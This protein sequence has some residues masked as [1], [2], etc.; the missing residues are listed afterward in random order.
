MNNLRGTLHRV[1]TYAAQLGLIAALVVLA[2]FLASGLPRIANDRTDA[3]L[4]SDI[5]RL[6]SSQRD[7]TFSLS[8]FDPEFGP[9]ADWKA[10]ELDKIR[11][12]LPAPLPGL[13]ENGWFVSE[14]GPANAAVG[15][16]DPG[17]C[18]PLAA[19]RRQTG[20]E[21]AVRITEGRMPKSGKVAEAVAG[22]DEAKALNLKIG[23]TL[24]VLGRW[25]VATVRVVG[26]YEV[27]DPADPF[28]ADM[29]LTR[30]SCPSVDDGTRFRATLLTDAAGAEAAGIGAGELKERW[31]YRIDAG[32]LTADRIGELTTAVAAARRAPPANTS[33][34]SSVDSTLADF[35]ERLRGVRALLAVVQAGLLATTAGLILLAARLA[36]DRRR[37]E[38]ALIRARGG[39]VRSIG[40]RSLA[41]T[42]LVALPAGLAG[43]LAGFLTGGRPDAGEPLLVAAIVLLAVAAPA[44]YAAAVARRPDFTG[45]RRDLAGDRPT[46]RRLTAEIFIVALAFGGTYLVR[47]RGLDAGAGVD[48]YLVVVPV[49]LALAA[50]LVALRLMPFPLRRLGRLA[51]RARGAVVFLGL[52]GA[53][54]G[55]PLRSGPL[56][57]LVVAIATGIFSSTV[58]TTV[59]HARD[60]AAELAIP[61]DAMVT[62]F[63][64]APG[65]DREVAAVDGVTA[66]VPVLIQS[67]ATIRGDTSPLLTQ[68]PALVADASAIPGMPAVLAGARPGADPVPAV[69]SPKLAASIGAGGIIDIQS[70]QY[71][72]R[73]AAVQDTVPGLGTGIR[74]FV[75]LPAQAMPIPDFQPIV[76]NRILIDGE[77]YDPQAV[78]KAADLGQSRQAEDATGTAQDT[79]ELAMPATLTTREAYRAELDN[80]GVDGVLAFT[81]AAGVAASA[82]LALLA[83]ALTVLAGAP[84]R[85]R[86]LSRLRTL[87]LS[88]RQGR[89]LLVFEL[90]PLISVAVLV[91]GLVGIALPALIG[92]ALGLSTFTAGLPAGISI[93]PLLAAGVLLIAA[94]AVAAALVVEDVANRRLRLG[95]VLRLGEEP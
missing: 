16:A 74:D 76:P 53:G 80:R 48:P 72:F 9:S 2:A 39:S 95:T 47:R 93:D 64:F 37:N 30:V 65:T 63:L 67:A 70:R 94:L 18:P 82:G 75:A 86:T 14:V 27:V 50:S 24:S 5:G 89:R 58:L 8:F 28:W 44:G 11:R 22:R 57:V 69:V 19:V 56:A 12:E 62:G 66:A 68:A 91:G 51:A 25:G 43:W 54:R 88:T 36:V 61:A 81:F 55:A 34:L 3:G 46:P 29:K 85:G 6:E 4:R 92:S 49:L 17:S 10:G 21:Q 15:N 26:V 79:F 32:K 71:K 73:V 31:R 90:V 40:A 59:S 33:L 13:I 35:D 20:A 60:R 84:D 38:Y 83:V 45:H 42:V 7:L 41:E 23:D 78:R 52:S 87:G 77:G 1:R